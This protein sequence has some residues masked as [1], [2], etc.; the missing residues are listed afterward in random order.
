MSTMLIRVPAQLKQQVKRLA[1]ELKTSEA[2][3]YRRAAQR[4]V[5]QARSR[6]GTI[7]DPEFHG[8]QPIRPLKDDPDLNLFSTRR[9]QSPRGRKPK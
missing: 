2:D 6:G 8:Y 7:F 9:Y 1:E 5:Q 3:I 4:Y